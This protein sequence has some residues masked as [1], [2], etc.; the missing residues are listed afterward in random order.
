[1]ARQPLGRL[2]GRYDSWLTLRVHGAEVTAQGKQ[3]AAI[4]EESDDA[5]ELDDEYDVEEEEDPP[6]PP[7]RK[8]RQLPSTWTVNA[9][10]VSRAFTLSR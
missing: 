2:T 6:L 7:V 4:E 8:K 10:T 5:V 9:M 3:H 1:M